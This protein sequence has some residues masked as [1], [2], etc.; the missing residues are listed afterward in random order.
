MWDEAAFKPTGLFRSSRQ[1]FLRRAETLF[2]GIGILGALPGG[3]QAEK[4]VANG[5][6]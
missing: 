4:W 3:L 1:G 6:R 5:F 2:L